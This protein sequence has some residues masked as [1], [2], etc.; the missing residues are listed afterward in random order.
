MKKSFNRESSNFDDACLPDQEFKKL[1]IEEIVCSHSADDLRHGG[2]C[3]MVD[4]FTTKKV[5]SAIEE[6]GGWS[7]DLVIMAAFMKAGVRP[8]KG[9]DG[10]GSF[11][12]QNSSVL[13]EGVIAPKYCPKKKF[14]Q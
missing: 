12:L 5:T 2:L 11:F 9:R 8:N 14:S 6:W 4:E 1:L 10:R 7:R 3:R 13:T